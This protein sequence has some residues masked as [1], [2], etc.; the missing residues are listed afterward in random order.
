MK[1]KILLGLV[2]PVLLLCSMQ[3][4][5]HAGNVTIENNCGLKVRYEFANNFWFGL[6][7]LMGDGMISPGSSARSTN[8]HLSQCVVRV[9]LFWAKTEKYSDGRWLAGSYSISQDECPING[10]LWLQC[11]DATYSFDPEGTPASPKNGDTRQCVLT[12]K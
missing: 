6:W 12:K 1:R 3:A 8:K 11:G 4:P 10:C 7:S 9:S 5:A 2:L